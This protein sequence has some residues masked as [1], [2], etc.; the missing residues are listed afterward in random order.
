MLYYYYKTFHKQGGKLMFKAIKLRLYPNKTQRSLINQILGC[1]RFVYNRGLEKRITDYNHGIKTGYCRTSKMLTE[2]K[3]TDE[4]TFLKRAD[5]VALQESLHD[6][7]RAYTNFFAK[8][9]KYPRF[10]SKHSYRQS[11]RTR[12]IDNDIRIE[13]KYVRLPKIGFVKIRQI[14]KNANILYATVERCPSGKYFAVL[15]V[16]FEPKP[17]PNK[18]GQIGINL[19]IKHYYADS[20]GNVVENPRSLKQSLKQ[21]ARVQRSLSRKEKYSQNFVKQRK[22]VAIIYEKVFNRRNDFL[23]KLSSM[24]INENQVICIEDLKPANMIKNRHLAR[25]ISDAAW[26]SFR[27]MLEYKSDWY[28]NKL[29]VIPTFYPSS[30]LC[31]HCGFKNT[32]VKNL[33]V[34]TW[35]CPQCSTKHDRDYNASMNILKYGLQ[36]LAVS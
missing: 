14:I 1:S 4:F 29:V 34:R 24:L 15:A 7:D 33:A 9:T 19:G 2:L 36:M 8:R 13:N 32:K 6:L 5:A 3:R 22:R 35:T 17:R 10:K 26:G 16:K 31:S 28:G 30:Q 18:G 27:R 12:N 21:L 23:Q 25:E 20:N 11:Y